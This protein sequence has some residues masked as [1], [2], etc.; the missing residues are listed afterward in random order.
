M[1][2]DNPSVTQGDIDEMV[3][4]KWRH[5]LSSEEKRP[6][7]DKAEKLRR[8]AAA[9]QQRKRERARA[10]TVSVSSPESPSSTDSTLE[11]D[12]SSSRSAPASPD[13][14]CPST[15]EE[16]EAPSNTSSPIPTLRREQKHGV[17]IA[18]SP[19][20]FRHMTRPR[21]TALPSANPIPSLIAAASAGGIPV[22]HGGHQFAYHP[23]VPQLIPPA[24][25]LPYLH[26][27]FMPPT[28]MLPPHMHPFF[29]GHAMP[30]SHSAYAQP[31]PPDMHLY[32]NY[33]GSQMVSPQPYCAMPMFTPQP[34]HRPPPQQHSGFCPGSS[35]STT[36]TSAGVPQNLGCGDADRICNLSIHD[37]DDDDEKSDVSADI[38][39]EP[40]SK[41]VPCD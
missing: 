10:S 25:P 17:K 28:S 30:H 3:H 34:L 22:A 9:K 18:P 14:G 4:H 23:M 1:M 36:L 27:F 31:V 15:P 20:H 12:C 6:Y 26:P 33:M 29:T 16:R 24:Y 32:G 11:S 35:V 5:V 2:K 8:D 21:V 39:Y 40:P 41:S 7:F 13:S 37:D 38:S 19:N